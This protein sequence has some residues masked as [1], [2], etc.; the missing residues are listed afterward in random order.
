M[1]KILI[2]DNLTGRQMFA[3]FKNV[4]QVK[5]YKKELVELVA[6]RKI[7]PIGRDSNPD[8]LFGPA[9]LIHD[10]SISRE[11]VFFT[12]QSEYPDMINQLRKRRIHDSI[13]VVSDLSINSGNLSD[14]KKLLSL[15]KSNGNKV[16]WI[17]HHPWDAKAAKTVK[18]MTDFLLF[19]ESSIYC[20]T[21]LV[22]MFLGKDSKES[23]KLSELAHLT[24]FPFL[25]NKYK[26]LC[27]RLAYS[28]VYLKYNERKKIPNLRK[29]ISL[30]A[31]LKFN[32]PFITAAYKNYMKMDLMSRKLLL[33][34]MCNLQIDGY[35]IGIGFTKSMSTNAA[36]AMIKKK[37]HTNTQIYVNIENGACGVRS[38]DNI[39]SV[40]ISEHF[41]GGGHPQ[42]SGF[43]VDAKKYSNFNKSGMEKFA[44]NIVTAIRGK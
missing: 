11:N 33:K 23:K 28:I 26:K 19:G 39:D 7:Y 14:G 12:Q 9:I 13:F 44:E 37:L 34:N 29:F 8:G 21:D 22:Y 16:I 42:A 27:D 18:G 32:D 30:A 15:L 31:E 36:C 35:N 20:A 2:Y 6:G 4:R 24:D 40:F 3:P 17:D 41:K 43:M 5:R 38:N 1:H 10:Y 25:P